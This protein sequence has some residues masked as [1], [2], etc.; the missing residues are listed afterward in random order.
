MAKHT[1]A[2]PGFKAAV[3]VAAERP[4][5]PTAGVLMAVWEV[6]QTVTEL[7]VSLTKLLGNLEL[8]MGKSEGRESTQSVRSATCPLDDSLLTQVYRLRQLVCLVRQVDA[9]LRL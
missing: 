1:E 9:V 3:E 7:E 6:G 4:M 2:H 8:V 5:E